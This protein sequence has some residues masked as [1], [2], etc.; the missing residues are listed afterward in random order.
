MKP[1]LREVQC[2]AYELCTLESW[3]LVQ[4]EIQSRVLCKIKQ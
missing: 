4:W 2:A 3:F 1:K